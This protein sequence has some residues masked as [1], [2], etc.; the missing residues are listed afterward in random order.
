MSSALSPMTSARADVRLWIVSDMHMESTRGWDLPP[1]AERPSFDVMIVAGDLITR[2][3]RGV[4][5]LRDRVDDR[6][7]IYVSGNHESYG[8][9][10]DRTVEKAKEAAFNTNVF[11]LADDSI[12]L[13]G[14]TYAGCCLWTDYCLY[15][16]R[17]RA[18][19]VAGARMNDFKKIRIRKY[20]ERFR[21]QDALSRH[22]RSR[23][24]LEA[25]LRKPRG[26]ETVVVVTHHAPIP[27]PADGPLDPAVRL[28][29]EEILTASYRSD[30][31]DLMWPQPMAQGKDPLRPAALWA[32]GHTHYSADV[33]I[34]LTRAVSNPKGYGPS[35]AGDFWE[36]RKFDPNFV[37]NI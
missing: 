8:A 4:R 11:V 33:V 13:G 10:L 23:A 1:P 20:A 5:W 6:P 31:R 26:D 3:E 37:V 15:G 36:N 16:D 14:V 27:D 9:D 2:M 18:M 12:Q 22:L 34:G 25:E 29:D 28:S 35:F 21:P 32:F 7:V 30:L 17:R 24:F 19:A